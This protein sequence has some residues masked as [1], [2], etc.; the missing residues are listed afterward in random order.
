MDKSTNIV[1]DKEY[2]NW[3]KKVKAKIQS[4]Q[5]KAAIAVNSGICQHS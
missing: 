3:L 4:S 1:F 2:K 5:I